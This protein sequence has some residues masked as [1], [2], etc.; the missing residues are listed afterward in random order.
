MSL[1]DPRPLAVVHETHYRYD[2]PV[3]L[4]HHLAHL[5]PRDDASQTVEAHTLS[6][7][8]QPAEVQ[9]RLDDQ[10]N[11]RSTFALSVP[12]DSLVVRACSRIIVRPRHEGLEPAAG[13][14]WEEAALRLR[15][16]AGAPYA[17]E[18]EYAFPSPYV[19]LHEE[20]RDYALPSFT[21]G[22]PVAE[23]AI[24]L[25]HRI[26]A[27]FTYAPASTQITTPVLEAFEARRGVCQDYAHVMLGGLR[28]LGLAARYVSGY[29]VTQPPP[30]QPRLIGADASHAWL[31]VHCPGL[32]TNGGWLDLDPTND[33]IPAADH[34]TLAYGRDYGDVTPLR[35][36]IR[37]GGGHELA[38]HVT[39]MPWDEAPE[40]LLSP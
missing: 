34:V 29:L 22:R 31:S 3:E 35:G 26:H 32:A 1:P 37:G 5:R 18:A 20:L 27:D 17:P 38:V 16:Q 10:G 28:A 36:V 9:H 13:M 7:S 23:A 14:P 19:P 6:I 4:A 33:L 2:A 21:P 12:H 8:P 39:V 15:Y 25:M 11:W 30:G 24:D 40:T